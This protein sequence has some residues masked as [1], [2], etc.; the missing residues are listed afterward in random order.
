MFDGYNAVSISWEI[1]L[2]VLCE[3]KLL[4]KP[5]EPVLSLGSLDWDPPKDC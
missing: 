3:V 5:T 1:L 2:N 4:S